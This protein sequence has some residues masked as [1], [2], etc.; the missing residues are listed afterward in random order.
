MAERSNSMTRSSGQNRWKS[1]CTTQTRRSRQ[2]FTVEIPRESG[3]PCPAAFSTM[4]LSQS[5]PMNGRMCL[6]GSCA[7]YPTASAVDRSQRLRS[8]VVPRPTSG[9]VFELPAL[10]C[11]QTQIIYLFCDVEEVVVF[12]GSCRPR[13]LLNYHINTSRIMLPR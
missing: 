9:S 2:L 3:S 6:P 13:L 11:S 10:R 8:G 1:L 7:P 12:G 4:R 5:C